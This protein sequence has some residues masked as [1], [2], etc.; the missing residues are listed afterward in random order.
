MPSSPQ[1][2][3]TTLW[4]KIRS[5]FLW[6]IGGP[7]FLLCSATVLLA[8]YFR[9]PRK[10][11]RL[12]GICAIIIPASIGIRFRF[13]GMEH[14]PKDRNAV[15]IGNHVNNF[16]PMA[17]LYISPRY[18]IA[19][20]KAKHFKWF[21]YGPMVRRYGNLPVAGGSS[22]TTRHSMELAAQ[23]L[24]EGD[25]MMVFPE[26]TRSKT[27]ALG[28]FRRG[29]AFLAI[30]AGVPILPFVLKGAYQLAGADLIVHPGVITVKFLPLVDVS[31][32]TEDQAE[33]LT[34]RLRDM[35][36]AELA[37]G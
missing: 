8:T 4:D 26:G 36:Q 22:E 20:E 14:I 6:C 9:P 2:H 11:H 16:D 25:S 30:R 7:T 33:E 13:E 35:I 5:F 12:M 21:V 19:L 29:G 27:G 24:K 15:W 1:P 34:Q 31:G 37:Q 28:K 23:R 18:I 17:I 3:P 32:Y 10:L